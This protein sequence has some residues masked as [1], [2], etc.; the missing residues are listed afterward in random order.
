MARN[1]ML[2][3]PDVVGRQ[4]E[5]DDL[6]HRGV[7]HQFVRRSSWRF[8]S[9]PWRR[10]GSGRFRPRASSGGDRLRTVGA[11]A[12]AADR[13][14]AVG[15]GTADA[16][17]AL[18]GLD[19]AERDRNRLV[20][21]FPGLYLLLN[22]R[23]ARPRCDGAKHNRCRA[24][25][26]TPQRKVEAILR[27]CVVS[28]LRTPCALSSCALPRLSRIGPSVRHSALQENS[29]SAGRDLLDR[30][31]HGVEPAYRR[32]QAGRAG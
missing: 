10:A 24:N 15:G 19:V 21:D 20:P 17:D 30:V 9:R 2:R 4:A 1:R 12:N 14:G 25:R 23:T 22:Q 26:A 32:S 27:T 3:G 28:V 31:Q 7:A 29:S 18:G 6:P 13:F 8:P 5:L 11:R 16:A